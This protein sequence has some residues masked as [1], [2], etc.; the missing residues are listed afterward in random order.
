MKG[1]LLNNYGEKGVLFHYCGQLLS[2]SHFPNN[3]S[4][5]FMVIVIL[6]L[7]GFFFFL[8]FFHYIFIF[9]SS[10]IQLL[11]LVLIG[12]T[13]FWIFNFI[14]DKFLTYL[15]SKFESLRFYWISNSNS[16]IIDKSVLKN[17]NMSIVTL[18]ILEWDDN[19][20]SSYP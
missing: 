10:Y 19:G 16:Y 2:I 14:Y 15:D 8:F 3:L 9:H 7:F 5:S 1:V 11:I 12:L 17:L 13:N 4:L 20:L 6:V 18:K